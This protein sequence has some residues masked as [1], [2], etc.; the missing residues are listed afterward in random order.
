MYYMT[1]YREKARCTTGQA[2]GMQGECWYRASCRDARRVLVQ[3]KLQ[4]CK[5]SAGTEQAAGMQGECWYRTNCREN[6]SC[7]EKA[8][9]TTGEAAGRRL[10]VLQDTLQ[11]EG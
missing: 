9:C 11:G 3:D 2:T 5:E 1:C 6:T 10:D 4:G 7:R 8:R